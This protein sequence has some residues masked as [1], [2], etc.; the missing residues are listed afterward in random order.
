MLSTPLFSSFTCKIFWCC[1]HCRNLEN[2][3]KQQSEMWSQAF[4][5]PVHVFLTAL[6][7]LAKS[8]TPFFKKKNN[9]QNQNNPTTT[10]FASLNTAIAKEQWVPL[11][12]KQSKSKRSFCRSAIC[13][14]C[15]FL[16]QITVHLTWI[17]GRSLAMHFVFPC[18]LHNRDDIVSFLFTFVH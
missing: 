14:F 12:L 7:L 6:K 16:S 2:W 10:T 3:R 18:H 17:T 4:K 11:A 15:D 8:E 9:K 5:I 1:I 13:L